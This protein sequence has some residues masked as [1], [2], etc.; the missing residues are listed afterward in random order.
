MVQSAVGIKCRDCARLPRSALVTL[1]PR[2]AARAVA[3][4]F[5]AGTGFGILL[6]YAGGGLGLGFFTIIIAFVVGLFTGR[7]VLKA[8]G[9]YR[10]STTAWI[11]AAG[12]AWAY[13]VPAVVVAITGS[14]AQAGAQLIG[15]LIAGFVAYR[16]VIS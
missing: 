2:T 14:G 1:K 10:S 8:T 5:G 11:A 16:E 13:V 6:G 12:A 15:L 4:A 3:A 7:A 9:R